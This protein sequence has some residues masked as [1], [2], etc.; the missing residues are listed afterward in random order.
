[1]YP[2]LHDDEDGDETQNEFTDDRPVI[3]K[4]PLA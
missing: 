4:Q 3:F 1:M 2:L